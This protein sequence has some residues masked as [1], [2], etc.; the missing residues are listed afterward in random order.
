MIEPNLVNHLIDSDSNRNTEI[1]ADLP[2]N[3]RQTQPKLTLTSTCPGF[4]QSY[5]ASSRLHH[6]STWKADLIDFVHMRLSAS[7]FVESTIDF[8]LLSTTK[9][10]RKASKHNEPYRVIMH[11]DMDCFF[12]S[13][14]IRDR[15]ELSGK[16]VAVAHSTGGIQLDYSS[17]E[18]AS[19]NYEA[20]IKGVKNGMFLGSVKKLAP[21]LI[22]IP[23]EFDKYDECSRIIYEILLAN[24]NFVQAVSCDEVYIDV[25]YIMRDILRQE[26]Y[27]IHEGVARNFQRPSTKSKKSSNASDFLQLDSGE[28]NEEGESNTNSS[29]YGS[30]RHELC[31]VRTED[32]H[33][34]NRLQELSLDYAEKLRQEIF[35]K[36]RGCTA[37]V[38]IGSN[39]LLA[40]LATK[41]A[42]P[43][44]K[45]YLSSREVVS[46]INELPIGDMPGFGWNSVQ[47]LT[48]LSLRTCEDLRRI[49]PVGGAMSSPLYH[50]VS[51]ELGEKTTM[52]LFQY[53]QGIDDRILE[54]KER[55][56]I[57][58]DIN[59]GIRF[60]THQQI[61]IFVNDFC[62]EVYSRM[63]KYDYIA[64]SLT[65]NMK[66]KLYEGEPGKF[67]GCGHCEDHSKSIQCPS[68]APIQSL[69][70]LKKHVNQLVKEINLVPSD[71]RGIGI[72]LKKLQHSSGNKITSSKLASM[73]A[74]QKNNTSLEA[75]QQLTTSS[76]TEENLITRQ[77][78]VGL[79]ET[80][81]TSKAS[82][83]QNHNSGSIITKSTKPA[84]SIA[85]FFSK[86]S[87]SV[88]TNPLLPTTTS[89]NTTSPVKKTKSATIDKTGFNSFFSPK[90]HTSTD[91][92]KSPVN[93]VNQDE[94]IKEEEIEF[95]KPIQPE[96]R[97]QSLLL[98]QDFFPLIQTN[99]YP[100]NCNPID[101]ASMFIFD[102]TSN[103][104]VRTIEQP[105][106]Q[107]PFLPD[108]LPLDSSSMMLQQTERNPIT[109]NKRDI[110]TV[111][112][113]EEASV[114]DLDDNSNLTVLSRQSTNLSSNTGNSLGSLSN[115]TT[116]SSKP[117]HSK[118]NPATKK[119]KVNHAMNTNAN[120]TTGSS[121]ITSFFNNS[122]LSNHTA[123]T[124]TSA[125]TAAVP[126]LS[127][128]TASTFT[129]SGTFSESEWKTK[130]FE[131]NQID[132]NIFH[133]LP[134]EI[135][136]EQLN[137]FKR[138]FSSSTH[139]K[140][141]TTTSHSKK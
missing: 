13:V 119:T 54:N 42:K 116:S 91:R 12:A 72:H 37:S 98:S 18:I 5:F 89:V 82:S 118:S 50:E 52:Q 76:I 78:T 63:V 134:K 22:V 132:S 95:S 101:T 121:K 32:L 139:L 64:Y 104:S 26:G 45:Y 92:I 14:G 84:N 47:K 58:A 73:F 9:I 8:G 81:A 48:K 6:L 11:V 29:I 62:E 111:L 55:Q 15:P 69:S 126:T 31:T 135:Q 109:S 40:R 38:G 115:G 59:W 136:Y 67:L 88:A 68:N 4:I 36:T 28:E 108:T 21:D 123:T 114:I 44:G 46:T 128:H 61:E 56:S 23:Y 27:S 25:T 86:L 90:R 74:G 140:V 87:E 122:R 125:L 100:T 66:K 33:L 138:N 112:I 30:A 137:E 10:I 83:N 60:T 127:T 2:P 79:T 97:S 17:S 102:E 41:K 94:V 93:T 53:I 24:A 70:I 3:D 110:S 105:T 65:V 20:R 80:T 107:D 131:I 141:S 35:V 130:Y 49:A 120:S 103:T 19:C 43:N 124:T 57:G 75:T 71:I 34:Q 106:I 117:Q 96:D 16:P 113:N 133:S 1:T 129:S 39:L 7:K 77:L 99:T 51:K 85:T